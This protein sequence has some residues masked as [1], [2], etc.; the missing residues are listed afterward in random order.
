VAS[1]AQLF[2][3]RLNQNGLTVVGD[4]RVSLLP[5]SGLPS[6]ITSLDLVG[7]ATLDL[8]ESALI[9]DYSGASPL[10]T[11]RENIISG[12]GGAGLGNGTWSG[13]GITSAA[14]AAL[15][16]IAP[17]S[18][19]VGYAE[20]A[21]LP[22]GAYTSFHG[23]PVDNTAILLV[24]TLMADATLDGVVGDDEVTILGAFYRPGA[25]TPQWQWGDFDYNGSTDDDDVTILGALYNPLAA[26]MATP[27]ANL[28]DSPTIRG[29]PFAEIS[30]NDVRHE[31]R[32]S[33]YFQI[34][35]TGRLP[36][37]VKAAESARIEL[38]DDEEVANWLARGVTSEAGDS[39]RLRIAHV[40]SMLFSRATWND[41]IWADELWRF[42][43]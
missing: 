36:A 11:I 39:H 21:L 2:T 6:V 18:H 41:A 20:N 23:Q 29:E 1:D 3:N 9:V 13:T 43:G 25:S 7:G 16:I 17:E 30:S 40:R 19:A 35:A 26:P 27:V 38:F 10:A 14:V 22:L 15:N 37:S 31:S 12:R 42:I 5:G 4:G 8:N 33:A 34:A 28:A 24:P 32:P